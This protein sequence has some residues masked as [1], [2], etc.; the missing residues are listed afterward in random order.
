MWCMFFF[1]TI[2][3]LFAIVMEKLIP[4]FKKNP[5]NLQIIVTLGSSVCTK[6]I[7]M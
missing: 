2:F 1:M 3:G 5:K 7:Y 4:V 6:M